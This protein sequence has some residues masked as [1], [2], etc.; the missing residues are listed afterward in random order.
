MKPGYTP[1]RGQYLAFI[2]YYSKLNGRPP[3]EAD[4]QWHFKGTPSAV[5]QMVL[6]LEQL[7]LIERVPGRPRTIRVLLP[8]EALPDL[9]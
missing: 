7:G 6:T 4:I 2:Y 9:E 1:K 3:S 8:R 5:H